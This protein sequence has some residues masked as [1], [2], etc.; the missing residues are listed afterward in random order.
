MT[1]AFLDRLAIVVLCAAATM[2][3][4]DQ[5][6]IAHGDS[7]PARVLV[8]APGPIG[9]GDYV[10]LWITY[11]ILG[12]DAHELTKRVACMPGERLHFDGTFYRCNGRWLGGV[13]RETWDHRPLRRF[14]F[15]GAI[16]PGQLFV[17]GAHPRSFDSRYFGLIDASTV[18][19]LVA[20]F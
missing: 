6:V 9:Q 5:V 16:P 7:V 3:A 18:Q 11:P 17:L 1:R 4:M 8:K 14:R 10:R 19:R 13:L 2:H 12:K 15:E 20:V